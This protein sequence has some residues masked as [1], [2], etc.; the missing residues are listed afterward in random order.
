MA[1]TIITAEAHAQ[2][3]GYCVYSVAEA[4]QKLG[5]SVSSIRREL[6]SIGVQRVAGRSVAGFAS[7]PHSHGDLDVR[8][9]VSEIAG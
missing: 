8:L 1:A 2:N 5:R 9:P 3:T 4:A 7:W 6:R